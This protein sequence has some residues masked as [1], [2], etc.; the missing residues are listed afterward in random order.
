MSR[1]RLLTLVLSLSLLSFAGASAAERFKID[2]GHSSALFGI[3]HLGVST[4]WGR[5]NDIQGGF[6]QDEDPAKA[7]IHVVIAAG[8]LDTHSERRDKHVMSPDFL[9]AKQFPE[10]SFASTSFKK[11]ADGVYDVTGDFSMHGVTKSITVR[12]NQVGEGAD[13]WGGHRSGYDA[14]F[15]IQRSDFGVDFMMKGVG[16]DVKIVLAIEGIREKK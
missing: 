13:P 15:T 2:G 1:A 5:F 8:S 16:D 12:V 11:I 7:S 14:Q 3:N 6:V 4:T 10:L 9:D